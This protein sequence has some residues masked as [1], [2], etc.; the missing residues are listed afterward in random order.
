[1]SVLVVTVIII[2][3]YTQILYTEYSHIKIY[4]HSHILVYIQVA[5][6]FILLQIIFNP[7][8]FKSSYLITILVVPPLMIAAHVL[9]LNRILLSPVISVSIKIF[10]SF[11][12]IC[13]YIHL[14]T[15][16]S[17]ASFNLPVSAY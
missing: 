3:I 13:I 15:T 11:I 12:L 17:S 4:M 7:L 2:R 16:T 10:Y 6:P 1:M 14:Y 8:N 9:L 5:A